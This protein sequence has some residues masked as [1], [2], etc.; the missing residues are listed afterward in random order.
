MDERASLSQILSAFLH[1][2]HVIGSLTNPSQ[3]LRRNAQLSTMNQPSMARCNDTKGYTTRFLA[4]EKDF[5]LY[6]A[7]LDSGDYALKSPG[8]RSSTRS[9]P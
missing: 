6:E 1:P 4:G 8:R 7:K 2:D 3:K 9:G 5:A